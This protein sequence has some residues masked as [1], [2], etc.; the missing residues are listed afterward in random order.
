MLD[1]EGTGMAAAA[2]APDLHGWLP[3]PEVARLLGMGERTLDR[4]I[5][6]KGYPEVRM[7][8]RDGRK[9]EP[10]VRPEDVK[11]MLAGRKVTV[12][13]PGDSPASMALAVQDF[14]G[15]A[16]VFDALASVKPREWPM[17]MG[18]KVASEYTGLS[19]A[20]LQRLCAAGRILSVKDNGWKINR[21][22]LK[23]SSEEIAREHQ[24]NSLD[25]ALEG[26]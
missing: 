26:V 2:V 10:V 3:K 15:I 25:S 19:M 7:R 1:A 20:F 11:Q 24:K 5:K 14:S 22:A 23:F 17:W 4:M 6:L 8:P 16:R 18:L 9:P 12:V 21:R 13:M